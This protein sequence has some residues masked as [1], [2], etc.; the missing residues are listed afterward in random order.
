ML[1]EHLLENKI[2][3]YEIN[4]E[5]LIEFEQS[6]SDSKKREDIYILWSTSRFYP[7]Q[8]ELLIEDYDFYKD[9]IEE[10]EKIAIYS[11]HDYLKIE[12]FLDKRFTLE[13]LQNIYDQLDAENYSGLN[14]ISVDMSPAAV[15]NV[16]KVAGSGMDV[17]VLE[18]ADYEENFET[19]NMFYYLRLN[20]I[21]FDRSDP[22]DYTNKYI[23]YSNKQM[24]DLYKLVKNN[25]IK[26]SD[27]KYKKN[28]VCYKNIEY[29]LEYNKTHKPVA[30]ID[31]QYD[32][33]CDLQ[34]WFPIEDKVKDEMILPFK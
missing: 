10:L 25:F 19:I 31:Y 11:S 13:Q 9:R 30:I 6:C 15:E 24:E 29:L 3:N 22:A 34:K 14:K 1:F 26:T 20:K 16:F 8:I 2:E 18:D 4:E 28:G 32:D 23:Q 17:C 7:N 27:H 5:K 12:K 21:P 33:M